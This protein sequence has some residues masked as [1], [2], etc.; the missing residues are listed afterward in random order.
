[1]PVILIQNSRRAWVPPVRP[2]LAGILPSGASAVIT[3]TIVASVTEADI[4]AGGKTL[5]ITLTGDTWI[6]AGAASFDLQRQNIINGVTSA[7]SEALGWNLVP[8]VLQSLAGVVRTSNTVVTITWDAFPTY[9]ITAQETITV[10]V[11][12]T[13]LVIGAGPIV[14]TPTFT[15]A[16]VAVTDA[17]FTQPQVRRTFVRPNARHRVT[18]APWETEH[19]TTDDAI[20]RIEPQM[21]RTFTRPRV[22][23]EPRWH[24]PEPVTGPPDDAPFTQPQVRRTFV[25]PAS[26]PAAWRYA[27]TETEHATTDD[28]IIRIEPQVRRLFT[29]PRVRLEPRW[30]DPELVTGQPDDAPFTQPQVRRTFVRQTARPAAWRLA[31]LETEHSTEDDGIL[32]IEPQV[33]RTFVRP[34]ARPP[35]RRISPLETEHATEDDGIPRFEPQVRRVFSRLA[36]RPASWRFTPTETE[37]AT[38]DDGVIRIE[39]QV[40]RTF[41]RSRV[42][43]E[44]RWDD[45]SP[46]TGQP[47]D[48]PFTQPQVRRVFSR[49]F[50]RPASWR[51]TPTETEHATTDDGSPAFVFRFPVRPRRIVQPSPVSD[52]DQAAAVVTVD[53]APFAPLRRIWTT[54][55][56]RPRITVAP[57]ETEHATTD[58]GV[59]RIEPQ[60]RRVFTRPR[61]RLEPR[62]HDPEPV[63]GQPDDAPFTLLA[64][65]RLFTRARVRLEPRWDDPSPVTG[66]SDDAPFTQP[67]VRRTFVRPASRPAAWRYAPGET[68]HATTDDGVPVTGSPVRRANLPRLRVFPRWDDL[69]ADDAFPPLLF[70]FPVR[71]PRRPAQIP[72]PGDYAPAPA[73]TDDDGVYVAAVRPWRRVARWVRG[74][75]PLAPLDTPSPQPPVLLLAS[76]VPQ[77]DLGAS[78]VPTITGSASWVPTVT[79]SASWVPTTSQGASW[80]PTIE[81][82]ATEG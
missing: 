37:H 33:R 76:W 51:F 78:W 35:A 52:L 3:G 1:M 25:R 23:I 18:I 61:V 46:V 32:R 42:R 39:P 31:P 79:G 54:F 13:A 22:R 58:D 48:A 6:A 80:S 19:A 14:A 62:W 40:R 4:V 74:L 21:R 20:I 10:T 73:V 7:Q 69:A 9:D 43:L 36:A 71:I 38:T 45:P 67:Q 24:D 41:V 53:D 66:Q 47:D 44:P 50:S 15:V 82:K 64:V 77:T 2:R 57:V 5:I 27:P 28:A 55:R 12:S 56:A 81:L 26:R 16:Q 72:T 8:K 30:H 17:P 65:R 60:V 63:T 68:E 34:F 29:R 49:L 70:R 59:I 75:F 11:P